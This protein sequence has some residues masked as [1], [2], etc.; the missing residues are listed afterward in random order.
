M[1]TYI[2]YLRRASVHGPFQRGA[3]KQGTGFLH[4]FEKDALPL[5]RTFL[6]VLE[7]RARI[8]P[9]ASGK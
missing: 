7:R 5:Q 8:S 2:I 4:L 6:A 9:F 1:Q 3:M